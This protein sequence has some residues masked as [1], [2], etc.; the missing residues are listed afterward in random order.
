[1]DVCAHLPSVERVK[2][3]SGGVQHKDL[4]CV[5]TV[6]SVSPGL[7]DAVKRL[8]NFLDGLCYANYI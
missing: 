5:T 8:G 6:D 1:M 4:I 2:K 3:H 7:R